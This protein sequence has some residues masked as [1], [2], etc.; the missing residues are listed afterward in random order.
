[1][2][3]VIANALEGG[4]WLKT[5]EIK[6]NELLL[7]ISGYT[8][9]I[10]ELKTSEKSA[11]EVILDKLATSGKD[12]GIFSTEKDDFKVESEKSKGVIGE[13]ELSIKLAKIPGQLSDVEVTTEE[14]E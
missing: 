6:G 10:D 8:D 1:L 7:T 12:K 3:D 11:G 14:E 5:F 2:I 9:D 4:C 13:I